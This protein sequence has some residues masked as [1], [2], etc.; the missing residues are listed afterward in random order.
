[1]E[2]RITEEMQLFLAG[3]SFYGDPFDTHGCWD[4]DNQIGQLWKRFMAFLGKNQETIQ[5]IARTNRWYEL[6]LY[7]E[8]TSQRGLFE[9]FVGIEAVFTEIDL[10]SK[11]PVELQIK[12]LPLTRYAVFTF[13]GVDITGDTEKTIQEWLSQ[14]GYSNGFVYSFQLYDERFKGMDRLDESTL[15]VYVPIVETA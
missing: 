4:E 1:M 12:I 7:D 6:H 15:D 5:S 11:M 3:M 10:L 14:T 9:V 13:S 2:P 8:Q